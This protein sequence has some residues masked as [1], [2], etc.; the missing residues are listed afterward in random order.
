MKPFRYPAATLCSMMLCC[1]PASAEVDLGSIDIFSASNPNS[2][3]PKGLVLGAATISGTARY[4][5]QNNE[6]YFIPGGLYFGDRLIYLGDRARYY[7][8]IDDK[9]A[10]YGYGRWRFGNFDPSDNSAFKGMEQR[11]GE[12]EAG[13][14]TTLITPYALLSARISSDVTGRSNGQELLLWADFPVIKDNLLIMPGMGLMIRS[15]NMANYY[16]GGV[17]A[18]EA[19]S[20]RPQWDTGT[21]VS[22]MAAIITSYRFSPHWVGMFAANY[23]LYDKDI[24]DSPLVQHNGELYGILA[25]G[26]TW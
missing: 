7:F 3:V 21:T 16:F 24:A 18:S 22:P 20:Q 15:S 19:T 17:S 25:V 9:V 6:T 12:F 13:I 10:F 2:P 1:S 4:E 14:G 23:E 26:Y 5:K 11:K 8:H